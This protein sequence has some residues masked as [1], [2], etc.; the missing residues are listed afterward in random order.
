MESIMNEEI[1]YDHNVEGDT[2]EGSVDCVSREEVL[3]TLCALK[4]G[5]AS[6]ASNVSC[7]YT[8]YA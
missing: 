8:M 4:A 1:D 5:K 3:Q 6:G 2:V 7:M